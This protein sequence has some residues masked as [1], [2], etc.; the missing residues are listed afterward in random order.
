MSH[1]AHYLACSDELTLYVGKVV[2]SSHVNIDFKVS[3][4]LSILYS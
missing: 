1:P 2:S 4:E 3:S